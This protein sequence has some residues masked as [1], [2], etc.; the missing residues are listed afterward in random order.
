MCACTHERHS[1]IVKVRGQLTGAGYL[2]APTGSWDK[3]WV[4]G[5]GS[6]HLYLLRHLT[7]SELSFF[8][9]KP[10]LGC[11]A[12]THEFAPEA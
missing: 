2:L 6:K 10:T 5:Y 9:P 4:F 11:Y 7:S 1:F 12:I 8:I 3:T